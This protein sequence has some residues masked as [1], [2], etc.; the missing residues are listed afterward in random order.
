MTI[1]TTLYFTAATSTAST[2]MIS[3]SLPNSWY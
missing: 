1:S 3:T 2:S